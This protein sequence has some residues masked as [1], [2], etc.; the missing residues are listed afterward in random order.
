MLSGGPTAKLCYEHLCAATTGTGSGT[1]GPSDAGSGTGGP[2]D[3]GSGTGGPT[4]PAAAPYRRHIQRLDWALVDIYVGDERVVPPDDE[5]ANDRL[6]RESLLDRVGIVGSFTPMPTS[7]P[8]DA[9][10]AC[11]QRVMADLVTGP[12]IDLIHLG[13]GPDGHTAS[14]FPGPPRSRPRRACWCWP[15]RI[16]TAATRTRGSPSRCR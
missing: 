16:P 6:I 14:L 1:G 4:T 3:A 12:G 13:M 11:Y 15:P 10:V 5:D 9:C 7:G 2:S 8:L